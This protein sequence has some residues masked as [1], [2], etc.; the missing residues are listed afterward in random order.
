MFKNENLDKMELKNT[1]TTKNCT[2]FLTR[3][4]VY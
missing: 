4:K 2:E 3:A 1:A